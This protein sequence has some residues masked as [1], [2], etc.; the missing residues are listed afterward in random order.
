MDEEIEIFKKLDSQCEPYSTPLPSLLLTNA[1]SCEVMGMCMYILC[2]AF[3]KM[4]D[5][6]GKSNWEM[7]ASSKEFLVKRDIT[8]NKLRK[9][10]MQCQAHGFIEYAK[11][12][13]KDIF[14]KVNVKSLFSPK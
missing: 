8:A 3:Q 6:E 14:V 2:E 11:E 13:G 7:N 12:V 4:R 10:L 1:V 9:I 5:T